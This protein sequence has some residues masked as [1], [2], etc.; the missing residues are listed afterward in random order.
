VLDLIR[1]RFGFLSVRSAVAGEDL[2]HRIHGTK[3]QK[4]TLDNL[5]LMRADHWEISNADR[6]I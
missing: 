4:A 1:V 6:S 5:V 3:T 2:E